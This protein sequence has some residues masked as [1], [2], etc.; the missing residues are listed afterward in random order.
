MQFTVASLDQMGPVVCQ[1]VR[2]TQASRP[3]DEETRYYLRL[4]LNELITNGFK[5]GGGQKNAVRVDVNVEDS[6]VRITVDD[7]G[8]GMRPEHLGRSADISSESG[9]GLAIVRGICQSVELNDRGNC[10]TAHLPLH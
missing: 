3:L 10:I 6:K 2:Q 7:G 8:A 4:V 9:R 1:L 5:H